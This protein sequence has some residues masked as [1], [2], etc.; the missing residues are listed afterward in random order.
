MR[1]WVFGLPGR[2]ICE[3]SPFEVKENYEHALEF[4]LRLSRPCWIR[5]L[6][7]TLMF[8]SPNARIIIA[9]VSIAIFPWF[10]QKKLCRFFVRSIVKSHHTRYQMKELKKKSTPP[11]TCVKFCTVSP[12]ICQYCCLPLHRTT[13]TI[14]KTTAPVPEI[15]DTSWYDLIRWYLCCLTRWWYFRLKENRNITKCQ[16][17]GLQCIKITV[18]SPKR[19]GYHLA[20]SLKENVFFLDFTITCTGGDT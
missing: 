3:Q 17:W 14:A 12:M 8:S 16:S 2:I 20:V 7:I 5:T 18:P 9:I 6:R 13:T 11:S 4:T 19:I 10:A 15:M 1:N